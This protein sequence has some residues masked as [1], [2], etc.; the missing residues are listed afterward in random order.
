MKV[1]FITIR[2]IKDA[3]SQL[4]IL[5]VFCILLNGTAYCFPDVDGD[6]VPDSIDNCPLIS[7]PDQSDLDMDGVGY[8]CDNCALISNPDQSDSDGDGMGDIC[9]NCPLISNPDQSDSDMDGVGDIC[10]NCALIPNADQSDSD[11]DGIGDVCDVPNLVMTLYVGWNLISLDKQPDY[12]DIATVLGSISDKV[13]SVWAYMGGQWQVYDPDNPEFSDL[14]TMEA[15]KGYW[16]NMAEDATL[17]ISGTIPSNSIVLS[18]GWNLVGYN[19]GTA[20]AVDLA[21]ASIEGQYIS[22]WAY[23]DGEWQVYDPENPGF[24][25]LA[26]MEPGYGY[27]INAREPCTW[28]LP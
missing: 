19:S 3:L 27:W 26:L 23:I 21:L 8:T 20:Y 5:F 15:G 17:T 11:M 13:I 25:D 16:V 18:S 28:V 24:S 2:F 9:D 14:E 7:N 22:V 1:T 6:G 4:I 12:T 10:D